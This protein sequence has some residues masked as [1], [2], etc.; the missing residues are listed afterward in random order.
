[1]K[2]KVLFIGPYPPPYSGP[3]T[4]MKTFLDSS[5]SERFDIAFLNTNVRTSNDK[6][7]KLD[8]TIVKAFFQFVYNL[9]RLIVKEKPKLAYYFVTA[10][11]IGWLGRDIW[12]ILLCRLL[13]VPI[14]I[15][16]RAGHFKKNY[17]QLSRLEKKIIAFACRRVA[18]A[19]VQADCLRDQFEGLV[20]DDRIRTLYNAIDSKYYT[21]EDPEGYEPLKIFFMGHLSFAKGYCDLL[22]ALARLSKHH[23]DVKLLVAGTKLKQERN[24]FFN[25]VTGEK[26]AFED[27]DD[28]FKE[29][30]EGSCEA[31]YEYLGLIDAEK[32]KQIFQECNFF[33]LPSYSEGFS[34]SIL[35]ALS[36]GKPVV[37]TPVGAMKE[38]IHDGENGF[39]VAPGD[40]EALSKCMGSL[41]DDR[42]L[43]DAMARR[44]HA[45]VRDV[46]DIHCISEK[47]GDHLLE[48]ISDT[49]SSS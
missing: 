19:L 18:R 45:Y 20:P 27:P 34:M 1:M 28:C 48:V 13:N 29:Y 26:I 46:F 16:M 25:A 21:N 42:E 11:R 22:K 47:L 10:T 37:C 39:L 5:L 24:V 14:V 35:E 30:L 15:H 31:N 6:K 17:A 8:H 12:C 44:N 38:I 2:E 3:E 7:G 23:K 40:I 32:K 36:M 41:I 33:V 49:E 43:R 4:A 9:V